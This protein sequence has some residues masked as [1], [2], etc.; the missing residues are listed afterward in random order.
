METTLASSSC[1]SASST[2]QW[3]HDVFLCFRGAD[4]GRNFVGHLYAALYQRG[5]LTYLNTETLPYG[6]RIDATLFK[7]IQESR[8]AVVVFSKNFVNSLICLNELAYII[9]CRDEMG[10]IVVPIYYHVDPSE[11]R[12]QEGEFNM[13]DWYR[14]EDKNKVES[15][16]NA[17]VEATNLSG[18]TVG[19]R[20]DIR[21][22]VCIK[23]VVDTIS[24]K[25]FPNKDDNDIG[26]LLQDTKLS[27]GGDSVFDHS[28]QINT[29]VSS[30]VLY[31]H[32]SKLTKFE[33]VFEF[34]SRGH[35]LQL[36]GLSVLISK[37]TRNSHLHGSDSTFMSS[38]Y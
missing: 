5:I 32:P 23:Q 31:S 27:S 34:S 4:T 11:V 29:S 10:Q 19:Y 24:N 33:C 3:N 6:L 21:E 7:A 13:V 38:S 16:R 1:T 22:A 20:H 15:W 9:H 36:C 28:K 35:S 2:R 14:K 12:K 18:W 25:L 17:L 37:P 30:S 26:T 8:I